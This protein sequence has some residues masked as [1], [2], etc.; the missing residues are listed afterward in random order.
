LCTTLSYWNKSWTGIITIHGKDQ[1]FGLSFVE[2]IFKKKSVNDMGI[3]LYKNLPNNLKDLNNAELSRR[4]LKVFITA[5]I[6]FYR[7]IP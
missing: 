6:L 1:V 3:K 4:K 5:Y 7:G 2:L